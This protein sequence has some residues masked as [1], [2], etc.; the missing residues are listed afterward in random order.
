MV[1]RDVSRGVTLAVHQVI[2]LQ[3]VNRSVLTREIKCRFQL[4]AVKGRGDLVIVLVV[5]AI[6]GLACI[7]AGTYRRIGRSGGKRIA[8]T[9]GHGD[10]RIR[11][12]QYV[13]RVIELQL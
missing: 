6:D 9:L 11:V 8:R 4:A 3:I 1:E 13:E 10:D 2:L 5:H 7:E 12:D